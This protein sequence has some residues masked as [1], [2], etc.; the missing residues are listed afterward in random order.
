[1]VTKEELNSRIVPITV[2]IGTSGRIRQSPRKIDLSTLHHE[3][4]F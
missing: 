4:G 2:V 1:M 3:R